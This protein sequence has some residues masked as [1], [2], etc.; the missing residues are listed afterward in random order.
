MTATF[1][2]SVLTCA[3]GA[4]VANF[5]F[6]GSV[7]GAGYPVLFCWLLGILA[8]YSVALLRNSVAAWLAG[9]AIVCSIALGERAWIDRNMG[10]P[11]TMRIYVKS[12]AAAHEYSRLENDL[13]APAGD[14]GRDTKQ[15]PGIQSVSVMGNAGISVRFSRS[16]SSEVKNIVEARVQA[17]PFVSHY[18]WVVR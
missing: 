14:L 1:L 15:L 13:F 12:G 9:A 10:A 3:V 8:G 4:I 7:G 5:I 17:S 11:P 16:M 18:V 6:G 2:L